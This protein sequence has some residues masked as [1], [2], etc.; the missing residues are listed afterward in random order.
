MLVSGKLLSGEE[1]GLEDDPERAEVTTGSFSGK[2]RR[3]VLLRWKTCEFHLIDEKSIQTYAVHVMY[4]RVNA[5]FFSVT[6]FKLQLVATAPVKLPP[7]RAF[8][9][10]AHLTLSQSSHAP[11]S[12]PCS[13]E[14]QWT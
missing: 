1:E 7:H 6:F 12:M 3:G 10:L 14:T 2:L 13:R 8:R 9:L 5:L 4:G 11:P